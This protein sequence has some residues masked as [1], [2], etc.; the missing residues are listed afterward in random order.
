MN[1][2]LTPVAV[3]RFE[4]IVKENGLFPVGPTNEMYIEGV[5]RL[6]VQYDIQDGHLVLWVDPHVLQKK[7]ILLAYVPNVYD[8]DVEHSGQVSGFLNTYMGMDYVHKAAMQDGRQPLRL[9][10]DGAFA[11]RSYVVEGRGQYFEDGGK[12]KWRRG[13]VRAIKDV[14]DRMVRYAMGDLSY[15]VSG[16]QAFAPMAG[17]S[18][19]RN[20]SLQPYTITEPTGQTSFILTSPSRVDV[21]VNGIMMR[22]LQ[23]DA[24]PYDL[25]DFPVTNGANDVKLIIT[26]GAGRVEEKD[27][28]LLSDASLL[29][30]GLHEYAYNVGV[31]SYVKAGKIHYETKKP[32]FSGF[33]R[34]GI[35]DVLT[36]GFSLQGDADVQQAGLHLVRMQDWG[37]VSA[38]V[39]V[40]HVD[41]GG[42]VDA[43]FQVGYAYH[44]VPS[45]RHV[46]MVVD[47]RGDDFGA[48]G[49]GHGVN[50]LSWGVGGRYSQPFIYNSIL[51]VNGRYRVAQNEWGNDWAYGAGVSKSFFRNISTYLSFEH[52]R[53]MG[54]GVLFGISWSPSFSGHRVS[55]QVDSLNDS[56]DVRWDWSRDNQW[57]VGAGVNQTDGTDRGEGYVQYRGNR[58]VIGA[59][60][61]VVRHVV[62]LRGD[63][64]WNEKEIQQRTRLN[65]G[66]A[67]AFVNDSVALSQPITDGFVMVRRHKNL[68]G[69]EIGINPRRESEGHRY[70]EWYVDAMGPAVI[71]NATPYMYRRF[72]V[73]VRDVPADYDLDK[74]LYVAKPAYKTGVLVTVGSAAN[75][76]VDGYLRMPDKEVV[77]LQA[78]MIYGKHMPDFEPVEFFTNNEGR[79]RVGQL[80]PGRYEIVMHDEGVGRGYFTVPDDAKAGRMSVGEIVMEPEG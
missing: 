23:L 25:S 28:S 33:H 26:D 48:L 29:K 62:P 66:V 12:N 35:S 54:A 70:A 21:Y 53:N 27:F 51:Q 55:A 43:A 67:V 74:D 11:L 13:N 65:A 50:P 71:A 45:N 42:A 14:P 32:A 6:S 30:K 37:V 64:A 40:S 47:Y 56:R 75:V 17:V 78:G 41:D 77:R 36:G 68:Q 1:E 18:I 79:F 58:G 46:T 8:G 59:R 72:Q 63:L 20:F 44:D 31:L 5:R 60:H 69:H 80:M 76:H 15:P 49:L 10:M 61:D 4:D 2:N 39:A 38:D 9:D 24:G 7:S 73:D 3:K 19:A 34:Y 52:R 16:L 57:H 22:S